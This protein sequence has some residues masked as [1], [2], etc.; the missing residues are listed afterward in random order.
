MNW[1]AV[2]L[3]R[4][5]TSPARIK[6]LHVSD[7]TNSGYLRHLVAS[8]SAMAAPPVGDR[9]ARP[10][11]PCGCKRGDQRDVAN[12]WHAVI[13]TEAGGQHFDLP[14]IP[15]V[16]PGELHAGELLVAADDGPGFPEDACDR[17]LT[18]SK[19]I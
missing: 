19:C 5:R 1:L 3:Q 9:C 4:S 2:S 18:A 17:V 13:E 7:L 12:D 15:R 10:R 6:N 8:V 11:L 16:H 14:A